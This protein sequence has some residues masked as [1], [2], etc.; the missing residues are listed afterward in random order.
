MV[1]TKDPVHAP[2]V[3][4]CR[5]ALQTLLR[6]SFY[7]VVDPWIQ[8]A[9]TADKWHM[10]DIAKIS[11]GGQR[12]EENDASTRNTFGK[13]VPDKYVP[14]TMDRAQSDLFHNRPLPPTPRR[15]HFRKHAAV[16]SCETVTRYYRLQDRPLRGQSFCRVL[17]D[18]TLKGL[19]RWQNHGNHEVAEMR[20]QV[21]NSLHGLERAVEQVPKYTEFLQFGGE[22]SCRGET[23][24]RYT[25]C[26][27]G[28]RVALPRTKSMPAH[29]SLPESKPEVWTPGPGSQMVKHND[30]PQT[31]MLKNRERGRKGLAMGGGGKGWQSTYAFSFTGAGH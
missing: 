20:G 19:E 31:Q 1:F 18:E 29:L 14:K 9:S 26:Q 13:P 7:R 21:I 3:P 23:M 2:S 6:P 5:R 22:S 30:T 11:K 27:R 10:L 28:R 15:E 17:N 4:E 25:D 12:L 8:A 24:L 16:P